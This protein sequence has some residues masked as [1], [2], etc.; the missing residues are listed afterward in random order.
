MSKRHWI[1][2]YGSIPPEIDADRYPS[3]NALVQGA[4][5]QFSDKPA[6]RAAGR[7]L[8]YADVDRLSS[9]FAA[10]LQKVVGVNKGD[11][12]AVMLPNVLSFPIAFIAIAKIGGIQVNVN[13][14]YTARELEHQLNDAGAK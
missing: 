6:F 3:V 14:L 1:Q 9:A 10:Y 11:R 5:C 13:P 4:L 7:T 8:T 12:V 2:S